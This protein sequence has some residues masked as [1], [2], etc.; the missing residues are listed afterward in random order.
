MPV[1]Y[2]KIRNKDKGI[3]KTVL[4]LSARANEINEGKKPM[5]DKPKSKRASTIAMKEFCDGKLDFEKDA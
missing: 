1:E 4:A 5:V 3:F 2:E